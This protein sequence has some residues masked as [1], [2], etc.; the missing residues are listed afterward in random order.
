M[1]FVFVLE[2]DVKFQKQIVEAIESIDP[3]IEVRLFT[4]LDGFLVW[5]RDLA[6]NGP[7]SIV[8][9]GMNPSAN[10]KPI[11]ET[12]EHRL[13]AIVSKLEFLGARQIPLLKKTRNMFVQKKV[14]TAEDPTAFVL[15][16]FEAP[17]FQTKQLEDRIINNVIMKPFDRLILAQHLTFAIDGRHK[18]SK[19]SITNQKWKLLSRC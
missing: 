4:N 1:K 18:P 3:K 6:A 13:V 12:E 17:N 19:Y 8:K 14:C 10:A 16:T 5:I 2:D 7:S 15:T 9:A 11:S